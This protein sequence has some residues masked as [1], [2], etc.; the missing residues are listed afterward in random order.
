MTDFR[1]DDDASVRKWLTMACFDWDE[2]VIVYQDGDLY[3][4]RRKGKVIDRTHPILDHKFN[5]GYGSPE[6]PC[7]IAK[8]RRATY[9]PSQYDGST[10]L[11]VVLNDIMAY[12]KTSTPYPGGS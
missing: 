3:S 11:V 6:C 8:D 1:C 2:G 7:F 4:K 9:F 10:E 12:T 5:S